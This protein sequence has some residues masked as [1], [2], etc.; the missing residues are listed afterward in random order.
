MKPILCLA[1]VLVL[2]ACS[3]IPRYAEPAAGKNAATLLGVEGT[4]IHTYTRRGCIATSLETGDKTVRV[5]PGEKLYV[6]YS[7]EMGS[8][9]VCHYL[10]SFV[11]EKGANYALRTGQTNPQTGRRMLCSPTIVRLQPDGTELMAGAKNEVPVVVP[12]SCPK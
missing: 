3:Q 1:P 7:R 12:A 4:S 2:C 9:A 10:M 11:P 8:N 6:E 5:R